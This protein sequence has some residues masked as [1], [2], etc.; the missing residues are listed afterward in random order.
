VLDVAAGTGALAAELVRRGGAPRRLVLVDRSPEMLRRAPARLRR[1]GAPPV[2]LEVADARALPFEA[3]VFD[4]VAMG[5]LVHLL[6][7]ADA[8]AALREAAR[9]LAPGGRAVVVSHSSPRGRGGRVY[10]RAWSLC[11]RLAPGL[12]AGGGPLVDAVPLLREAGLRPLRQIRAPGVYWSQSLLAA[13][14]A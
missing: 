6:P 1:A 11:G 12:Q 2:R 5:F 10:R 3:G 7:R 13:P 9:V 4:L 14:P 8:V